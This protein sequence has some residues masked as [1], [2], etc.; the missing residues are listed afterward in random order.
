MNDQAPLEQGIK[1]FMVNF[2]MVSKNGVNACHFFHSARE[3]VLS[4]LP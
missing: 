3:F 1:G 4:D 2:L